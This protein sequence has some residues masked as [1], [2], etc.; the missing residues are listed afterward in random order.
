MVLAGCP[1][2][3]V[4]AGSEEGFL[5]FMIS[6]VEALFVFFFGVFETFKMM[7]LGQHGNK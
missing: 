2:L 5:E 7:V 4:G 3:I 1:A 6:H